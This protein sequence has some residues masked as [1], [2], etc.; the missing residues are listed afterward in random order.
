M[1]SHTCKQ[2][3][4]LPYATLP[5]SAQVIP[6]PDILSSDHG[7]EACSVRVECYDADVRRKGEF[8]GCV[9]FTG[10]EMLALRAGE[11]TYA[12]QKKGP[13]K[14]KA[15]ATKQKYVKGWL[16]LECELWDPEGVMV[17]VEPIPIPQPPTLTLEVHA[18]RGLKKADIGSK[19]DAYCIVYCDD[20]KVDTTTVINNSLNPKWADEVFIVA[21][22]EDARRFE[23]CEMRVEVHDHDDLSKGAF[24]G[25]IVLKGAELLSLDGDETSYELQKKPGKK[26][27]KY[28]QGNLT[29]SAF[30]T[31]P[32]DRYIDVAPIRIKQLPKMQLTVASARGLK[33]ADMFGLSD[34]K[35]RLSVCAVVCFCIGNED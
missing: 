7:F 3:W 16:T 34:P 10:A 18:A 25:E 27:Q 1:L 17:E 26:K 22:P 29:V 15:A 4:F 20:V 5:L 30:V 33:K 12:L 8:L 35:V 9:S 28:V 13:A 19:S 21:L 23:A 6:E 2:T 11:Q 14:G 24:L 31:D 32:N